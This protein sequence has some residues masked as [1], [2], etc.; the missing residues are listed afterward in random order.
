M[1]FGLRCGSILFSA[2]I[3]IISSSPSPST[4][5]TCACVCIGFTAWLDPSH[6]LLRMGFRGLHVWWTTFVHWAVRVP[7]HA[8]LGRTLLRFVGGNGATRVQ[9]ESTAS[10]VARYNCV[11]KVSGRLVYSEGTSLASLPWFF[12]VRVTQVSPSL[13]RVEG[14][15]KINGYECM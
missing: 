4:K 2:T 9:R 1:T 14:L 11:P 3:K 12:L 6:Q 5:S 13:L 15:L 8:P 7:L 10:R